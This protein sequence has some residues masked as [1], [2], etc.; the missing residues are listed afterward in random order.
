MGIEKHGNHT[1]SAGDLDGSRFMACSAKI[2]ATADVAEAHSQRRRGGAALLPKHFTRAAV[3]T[4][5]GL[6]FI[7]VEVHFQ[8]SK[9]E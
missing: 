6:T 9:T 8:V 7:H 1:R 5:G 2:I 4:D 3:A